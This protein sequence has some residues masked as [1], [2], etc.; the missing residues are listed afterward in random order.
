MRRTTLLELKEP[1]Q[2]IIVKPFA[3]SEAFYERTKVRLCGFSIAW[4]FRW[5]CERHHY[6]EVLAEV[7]DIVAQASG[8]TRI[9]TGY[10]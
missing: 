7:F 2:T 4:I 8:H 6:G 10:S 9:P 3:P 5:I 1:Y